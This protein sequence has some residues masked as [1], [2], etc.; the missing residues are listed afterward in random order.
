MFQRGGGVLGEEL[1]PIHINEKSYFM[2]ICN[3]MLTTYNATFTRERER[4]REREI[5]PQ[6]LA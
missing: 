6:S 4:E 3:V 2:V 1:L 5:I